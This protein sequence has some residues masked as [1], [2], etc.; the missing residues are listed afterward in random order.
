MPFRSRSQ[1]R[2]MFSA[3]SKGE[4]PKGTAHRW[5][6]HTKRIK[7]LPD[8]VKKAQSAFGDFINET[9]AQC[10]SS[11]LYKVAAAVSNGRELP[12]ALSDAGIVDYSRR[13]K[14][15]VVLLHGFLKH[16]K[17]QKAR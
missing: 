7:K 6:K 2:W 10:N 8:H 5:A 3:E 9:A 4:L 15:A 17:Q 11:L 13:V 1:Q 16:V 14:V 12:S